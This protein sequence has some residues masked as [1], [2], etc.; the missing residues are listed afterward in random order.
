MSLLN[1]IASKTL[2]KAKYERLLRKK[3]WKNYSSRFDEAI[4]H[5][6]V[7]KGITNP[8]AINSQHKKLVDAFVNDG[9]YPDEYYFFNYEKLSKKGIHEFVANREAAR[10]WNSLNTK[11]VYL[12]TC[13]KGLTY[14]HFK[15]YFYRDLVSVTPQSNI[16]E[17]KVFGG[18]HPK[19]I[20]KPTFGNYGNGVQVID[21]NNKDVELLFNQLKEEYQEGF[22]L[23][24]LIIQ[25]EDLA[26]FHP[27]S[28]NTVRLTTVRQ[29][30]GDIYIIH[31]PF[32]RLGQGGRCVDNGGNG[33]IIAG[34]DYETGIIKGA[35]DER[36]NRYVVHP[37]SG[38]TILGYQIPR[39]KEAKEFVVKLANVLPNLKYCGWDL[40][41]TDQGWIMVEANGKGLFIGFQMPTQEGFRNEFEDLKKRCGIK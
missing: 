41:L 35:I 3:N 31:R 37:D 19:F 2:P 4:Q 22:T 13:D 6:V 39:W 27:S 29:S 23:E 10:F 32:I 14:Q 36:M 21:T 33:G 24:E 12:L 38:K 28:V 15:P 34:I 30:N 40:A 18:N 17:Y 9:W 11:E 26:S 25:C 7:E 5:F 16:S 20:V 1:I 8:D